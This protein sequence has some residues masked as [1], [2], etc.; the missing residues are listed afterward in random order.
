MNGKLIKI[1][2][3][4]GKEFMERRL[5]GKALG[6]FNFIL[7]IDSKNLEGWIWRGKALMKLHR[8]MKAIKSLNC[9]LLVDEKCVEAWILKAQALR[10]LRQFKQEQ[11]CYEK[12]KEINPSFKP[13]SE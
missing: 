13:S 8:Y 10:I 12:I 6:C 1:Y 5:Y 9:A 11:E 3:K 4:E 2:F 7:E